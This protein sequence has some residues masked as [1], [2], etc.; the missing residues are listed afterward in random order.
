MGTQGKVYMR[1]RFREGRQYTVGDLRSKTR[2]LFFPK[3]LRA[4]GK[5]TE[6]EIRWLCM[7]TW[8]EEYQT[9]ESMVPE[10]KK[11]MSVVGW[12]GACWVD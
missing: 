8:I 9:W 2:F 1:W 6:L 4:D 11:P 10:M 3:L 5:S 12:R 7:S